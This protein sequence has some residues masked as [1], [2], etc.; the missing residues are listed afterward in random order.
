VDLAQRG[1]LAVLDQQ[2]VRQAAML[3]YNDAWMLLL[4]SF[5]IVAPAILFLRRPKGRPAGAVDAH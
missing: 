2:V 1:A 4:L 5:V 3:S